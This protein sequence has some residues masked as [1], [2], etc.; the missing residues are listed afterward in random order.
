[1][2]LFNLRLTGNVIGGDS[3]VTLGIVGVFM[4]FFALLLALRPLKKSFKK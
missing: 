2:T 1:M 3:N 4:I